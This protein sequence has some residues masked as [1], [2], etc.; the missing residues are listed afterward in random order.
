MSSYGAV[1]ACDI[2]LFCVSAG[3]PTAKLHL[4]DPLEEVYKNSQN[5]V[6]LGTCESTSPIL[7]F[8]ILPRK[9]RTPWNILAEL[10][11]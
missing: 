1:R 5:L 3:I 11:T 8:T 2:L 7:L 10:Q 4:L 9:L 6:Q